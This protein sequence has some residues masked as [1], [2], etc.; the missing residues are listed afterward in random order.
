MKPSF[1]KVLT[2][3]IPYLPLYHLPHRVHFVH[4]GPYALYKVTR[5]VQAKWLVVYLPSLVPKPVT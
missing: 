1:Y 2:L 3:T 5:L 4:G